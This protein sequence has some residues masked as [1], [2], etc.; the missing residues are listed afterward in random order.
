M[1]ALRKVRQPQAPAF[2]DA[3]RELALTLDNLDDATNYRGWILSLMQPAFGHRVL[4]IG[5]GHGTF[6]EVLAH[7]HVVTATELSSRSVEILQRRFAG[8]PSVSV[9]EGD[10]EVSRDASP[11][12]TA[13]MI[14]VLEHIEDDAEALTCLA[15]QL[16]PGGTVALWVPAHMRL[17][18]EFDRAIGH[19]RRYTKSSLGDLMDRSGFTV[20]SI[21]YVNAVGAV[22]WWLIARLLRRSPTGKLGVVVFDRYFI[23]V[24]RRVEGHVRVPFGQSILAI[25]RVR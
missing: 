15:S 2:A 21:R 22:A 9:L 23:P 25:G 20:E 8:N 3:D 13:V 18:S 7:D 24:L 19:H 10:V 5:A 17:Y 4:E 1:P 6:T 11:F 16:A 12:D 14:N